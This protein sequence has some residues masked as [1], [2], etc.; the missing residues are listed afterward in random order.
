MEK[1]FKFIIIIS[2]F[3]FIIVL[4]LLYKNYNNENISKKNSYNYYKIIISLN[5]NDYISGK[6]YANKIIANNFSDIYYNLSCFFLYEYYK[7]KNKKQ[8]MIF[9]KQK[10]I[11]NKN[12]LFKNILTN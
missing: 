4:G 9:Y 11:I 5:D 3:I 2:I 12:L 8:K 6:F 1:K 10:L 7:N